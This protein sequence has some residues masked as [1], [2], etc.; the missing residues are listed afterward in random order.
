MIGI[1]RYLQESAQEVCPTQGTA[2]AGEGGR[3]GE[4]R[5]GEGA[6]SDLNISSDDETTEQAAFH[7]S[8]SSATS[9]R[10]M[11]SLQGYFGRGEISSRKHTSLTSKIVYLQRVEGVSLMGW[12]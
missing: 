4:R 6:E 3:G 9:V 11:D 7:L 2:R 1:A 5:R 12:C 8:L 10:L